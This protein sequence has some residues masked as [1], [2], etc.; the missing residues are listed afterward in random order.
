VCE[1]ERVRERKRERERGLES[2]REREEKLSP[3]LTALAG[4]HSIELAEMLFRSG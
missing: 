4:K 2:K 1:R 3:I